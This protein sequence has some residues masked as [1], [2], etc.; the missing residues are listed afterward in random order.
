[1]LDDL[2]GSGIVSL[3]DGTVAFRHELAR[4]AVEDELPPLRSRELHA[5]ILTALRARGEEPT[6]LARLVHHAAR[7]G[8]STSLLR[9]A[10]LAAEHASRLGAHREAEAHLSLALRYAAEC[11][12]AGAP[13]CSRRAHMSATSPT[14][15]STGSTP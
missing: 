4:R 11:L 7:A 13:S 12:H 2:L 1:A 3:D 5:R 14:G 15:C 6:H 9:L 10:P 8:D